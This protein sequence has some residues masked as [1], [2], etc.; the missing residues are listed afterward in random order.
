MKRGTTPRPVFFSAWAWLVLAP[1]LVIA[2]G[3]METAPTVS[4]WWHGAAV[5][6]IVHAALL[7]VFLG[8]GAIE[9]AVASRPRARWTVVAVALL[10]IAVGRPALVSALQHAFGLDLVETQTWIRFLLNLFV[11]ATG[12]ALIYGL[13]ESLA[14]REDGRQRLLVVLTTIQAQADRIEATADRVADEFQREVRGPVLEA[15]DALVPRRLPPAEL[16]DELRQVA[17]DVVRPLSHRAS[18]VDLGDALGDVGI[19]PAAVEPQPVVRG[20]LHQSRIAPA[21]AWLTTLVAVVV[22]V[23]AEFNAN[24]LALGAALAAAGAAVSLAGG[25]LLRAVPLPTRP[26][27]A[28]AGLAISQLLLGALVTATMLGPVWATPKNWYYFT[29]GT[30]G[31]GVVGFCLGILASRMREVSGHHERI[32][33][34][35]SDAEQRS[36]RARQRLATVSRAT[37]RLLHTEIQG[38]L[39]ATSL[40]L[41]LGTAGD[42]PLVRLIERVDRL[43]ADPVTGD[44]D[45]SASSTAIRDGFRASLHA[46]SLSLDLAVEVESAALDRLADRP[47][48][49][50]VAHDALTEG[51]TNAVRHGRGERAAVAIRVVPDSADAVEVVVANPGRI[52]AASGGGIGL[53]DLRDRARQVSLTQVGGDVVLRVVA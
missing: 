5:A 10:A 21:A 24:G 29:I 12:C 25:L 52:G 51:L 46:W 13:R 15:L 23:P 26:R 44:G 30:V 22:L 6:A 36:F 50:A 47:P 11:I 4:L 38:D 19:D 3:G 7:G 27:A 1:Y 31:Y 20:E 37:G 41:R 49:A 9:T 45:L 14:R 33:T 16:S 48:S 2:L 32:A 34:A 35:V 28:T 42:E 43:L 53:K 8:L 40:Q 17:H 39:I 18:D